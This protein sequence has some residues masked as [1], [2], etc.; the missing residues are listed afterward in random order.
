MMGRKRKGICGRNRPAPDHGT[1][2]QVCYVTVIYWRENG[3]LSTRESRG[4]SC[5]ST[6]II[7]EDLKSIQGKIELAEKDFS[8]LIEMAIQYC[9]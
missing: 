9:T 1:I 5:T 7:E 8:F 6:V 2:T 3:L 4:Q